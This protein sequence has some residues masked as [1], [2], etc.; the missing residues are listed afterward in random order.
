MY[1]STALPSSSVH[2]AGVKHLN[3]RQG[4]TIFILLLLYA[5]ISFSV[6][7]L[8]PRQGITIINKAL[9]EA[10]RSHDI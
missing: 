4:I 1:P 6:K 3:P 10:L 2:P 7:H 5:V 8:N 9:I